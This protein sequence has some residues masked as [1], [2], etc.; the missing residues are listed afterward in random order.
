MYRM[1]ELRCGMI[2]KLVKD[3]NPSFEVSYA[4]NHQGYYRITVGGEMSSRLYTR[5]EVREEIDFCFNV[6]YEL[7]HGP[8]NMFI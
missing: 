4:N 7:L 5:E 6:G 1:M 8:L 2:L 3:Y